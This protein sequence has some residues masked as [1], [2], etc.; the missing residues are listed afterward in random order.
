MLARTELHC[1]RVIARVNFGTLYLHPQLYAHAASHIAYPTT[2][3]VTWML[4]WLG[5][6][7]VL[8][9][10]WL[11]GTSRNQ[12][13][14]SVTGYIPYRLI[15]MFRI[16]I[17]AS[18]VLFQ[19]WPATSRWPLFQLQ[20]CPAPARPPNCLLFIITLFIRPRIP[21]GRGLLVAADHSSQAHT[22]TH[23]QMLGHLSLTLKTMK[24]MN[25]CGHD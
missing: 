2:Q 13:M 16:V 3:S 12:A 18:T 25:A 1:W 7:R 4:L 5:C 19:L 9:D 14:V 15:H 24:Y 10:G 8:S 21:T 20:I 6:Q 23:K 17:L 22:D 11:M